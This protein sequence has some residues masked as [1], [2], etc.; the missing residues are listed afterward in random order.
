MS[1]PPR[2]SSW[3]TRVLRGLVLAAPCVGP[4]CAG[5]Q[6]AP[7]PA[8]I[9]VP[10]I[11]SSSPTSRGLDVPRGLSEPLV[12][13]PRAPAPHLRPLRTSRTVVRLGAG[14]VLHEELDWRAPPPACPLA[15]EAPCALFSV[16][17]DGAAWEPPRRAP[18]AWVDLSP[19]AAQVYATVAGSELAIDAIG[20][21]GRVTR[22]LTDSA[23]TGLTRVQVVETARGPFLIAEGDDAF[24]APVVGGDGAR[25]VGERT[26]LRMTSTDGRP[27]A[28]GARAIDGTN[29]RA[30]WGA[31]H[32]VSLLG[33]AGQPT[34]KW[35]IV[36]VRVIP[37]PF[38]V[39]AG[40][41]WRRR[42][43][44]GKHDCSSGPPSRGLA[45]PSVEK[46]VMLT[47]LDGSRVEREVSLGDAPTLDVEAR[48]LDVQAIPDGVR[49]DDVEYGLDGRRRSSGALRRA[50]IAAPPLAP[51]MPDEE[52]PTGLAFDA[53]ASEG[54]VVVARGDEESF[55]RLFRGDGAFLGDPFP[56]PDGIGAHADAGVLLARV[57]GVWIAFDEA[58][59]RVAWLTGPR[60]GEW[61]PVP[62]AGHPLAL[63][64]ASASTALLPFDVPSEGTSVVS[65]DVAGGLVGEPRASKV[66]RAATAFSRPGDGAP[67]LVEAVT[68]R[69]FELVG[70]G[71][72]EP[73]R[74]LDGLVM[75]RLFSVGADVVLVGQV[76]GKQVAAWLGA[77][78]VE[79]LDHKPFLKEPSRRAGPPE[80]P[81][82]PTGAVLTGPPLAV[83]ELPEHAALM[84]SCPRSVSVARAAVAMACVEPVS[85]TRPELRA[86][87]RVVGVPR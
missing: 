24:V 60:A 36:W 77:G 62:G 35:A 17:R 20:A 44:G 12:V 21:D 3:A 82:R 81:A 23:A 83:S 2:A 42:E 5:A 27:N 79:S 41:P 9:E 78:G 73:P 61:R 16:S 32:P 63:L 55:G 13:L 64:P 48:A 84:A 85:T 26:P 47:V 43:R 14:A 29:G 45:D 68:W 34:G 58:E 71:S 46:R 4:A 49:V 7:A 31:R 75:P 30:S 15:E 66:K 11:A 10:A 19:G 87:L 1:E 54:L 86:V 69:T 59:G 25:R 38:G 22:W 56:M 39:K 33:A 72:V 8:P 76:A 80:A 74:E 6:P 37:P 51:S 65:I 67:L 50:E 53:A 28:Q 52:R 40:K 18:A 57:G 70:G